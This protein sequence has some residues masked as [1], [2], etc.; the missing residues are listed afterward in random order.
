MLVDALSNTSLSLV[1]SPAFPTANY[2]IIVE[3]YTPYY[4]LQSPTLIVTTDSLTR[5]L[6]PSHCVYW[7][8]P[9][10]CPYYRGTSICTGIITLAGTDISQHLPD[11]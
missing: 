2:L 8:C 1:R 6:E 4:W 11:Q 7:L 9:L 5:L 10:S 3:K